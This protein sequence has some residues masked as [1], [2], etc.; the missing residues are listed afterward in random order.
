MG[1]ARAAGSR[2]V[3]HTRNPGCEDS[4]IKPYPLRFYMYES[5]FGETFDLFHISDARGD[6]YAYIRICLRQ[7]QPS[8]RKTDFSFGQVFRGMPPVSGHE[9]GK[10]HVGRQR[11]SSRHSY[12]LRRIHATAMS[13]SI[14]RSRLR[15]GVGF[16][17]LR[18]CRN[19][20][21]LRR[22]VGRL[23]GFLRR[24]GIVPSHIFVIKGTAAG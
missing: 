19:A 20:N 11:E 1:K 18:T 8:V 6:I 21:N 17:R 15:F 16:L 24:D 13:I 3:F 12:R 10:T 2:H 9:S 4:L 23:M 22:R 7:L 14:T 5:N